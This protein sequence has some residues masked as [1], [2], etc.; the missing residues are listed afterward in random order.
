MVSTP[1]ATHF[2][3]NMK[4]NP[5]TDKEKKDMESVPYASDIGS[6]MY[7]MEYTRPDLAHTVGVVSY[8]L[9]NPSREH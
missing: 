9:S 5:T 3:L 7:A 2:K 1:L 4:Q 6:L 8:Y